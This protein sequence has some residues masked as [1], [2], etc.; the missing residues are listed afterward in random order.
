MNLTML[1]NR[2]LRRGSRLSLSLKFGVHGNILD[3]GLASTAFKLSFEGGYIAARLKK[4]WRGSQ[5][6]GISNKGFNSSLAMYEKCA[7]QLLEGVQGAV[8]RLQQI[9]GATRFPGNNTRISKKKADLTE[10]LICPT[11]PTECSQTRGF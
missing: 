6:V 7:V 9:P 3:K 10:N 2:L 5:Y 11:N 1:E 8:A 4:R